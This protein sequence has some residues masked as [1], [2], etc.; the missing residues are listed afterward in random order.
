MAEKR[1]GTC[2]MVPMKRGSTARIASAVGR[3]A[4][5]ATTRPSASSVSRSSPQRTV[6]RYVFWPSITNG[7]VLVASP[8]AIGRQ[9]EASGSRVPA[10]PARLA[11]NS[12]LITDTA[13]VEVMPTGLS[14]TTQPWTSNFSRLRCCLPS[15]ACGGAP[16]RGPLSFIVVGPLEV[17]LHPRRMQQLLDARGLLEPLVDAEAD[18]GR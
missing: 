3:S 11:R 8:S 7:T 13:W 1:G 9:P 16:G 14:S 15:P 6:K 12:R 18:V 17:A 5:V 2:A 10:W 4:L